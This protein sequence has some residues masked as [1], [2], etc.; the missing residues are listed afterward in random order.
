M[1]AFIRCPEC[2]FCIGKYMEFIE[3]AKESIYEDK[4][5]GSNSQF[6]NYDPEKMVFNP[7]IIPSLENLF[8]AVGIINRCC[9][10]H[11]VSKTEFS[12]IYK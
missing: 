2:S 5:F 1:A 3:H 12:K 7:D 9:R 6:S 8:N 4:V 11:I 10:M